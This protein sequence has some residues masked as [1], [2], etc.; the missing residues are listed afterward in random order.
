M[1]KFDLDFITSK[2]LKSLT[3]IPYEDFLKYVDKGDLVEK[4]GAEN[5]TELLL[6]IRESNTDSFENITDA[7]QNDTMNFEKLT[8]FLQ[9]YGYSDV[10]EYLTELNVPENFSKLNDFLGGGALT[11]LSSGVSGLLDSNI[12]DTFSK[13]NIDTISLP[14][15]AQVLKSFSDLVKTQIDSVFQEYTS[16]L[17]NLESRIQGLK[18]NSFMQGKYKIG[19]TREL[20]AQVLKMKT[21][22]EDEHKDSLKT[23][24][25]ER[26]AKTVGDID[27]VKDQDVKEAR[28]LIGGITESISSW[29]SSTYEGI[30]KTVSDLEKSQEDSALKSNENLKDSI[31]A[32]RPV[33]SPELIK[34]SCAGYAEEYG[35]YIEQTGGAHNINKRNMLDVPSTHPDPSSWSNLTFSQ[36]AVLNMT[37]AGKDVRT[38]GYNKD[39]GYY[40]ADIE[41]LTMLNEVGKAMGKRLNVNS[42]Y[43]PPEYNK[44]I[45]GAAGSIHMKGKALDVHMGGIDRALF[46]RLC[47]E[48]GFDAFGGYSSFIHVDNRGYRAVWGLNHLP[49][50]V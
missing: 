20:D 50:G 1:K 46:V 32:G 28:N 22:L 36:G 18:N 10:Q 44:K 15:Q 3:D 27:E 19:M 21:M 31:N 2:D 13:L 29:I 30:Q 16:K 40:G 8:G 5:L 26:T 45:G 35:A 9:E 23:K 11:S 7:L 25:D 43:R 34:A 48:V 4:F 49:R 14:T 12:F 33:A 42:A 6:K 17:G 37:R 47:K 41:V 24:V 39:I 38:W